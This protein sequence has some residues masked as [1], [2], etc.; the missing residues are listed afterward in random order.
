MINIGTLIATLKLNDKLTP[1]LIKAQ[2]SI[3][4]V[5]PKL[6]SLGRT[7][8]KNVTLGMAAA[9]AATL[10]ASDTIQEAFRAISSTTGATGDA[11]EG[12]T[13]SFTEVFTK[14]PQGAEVVAGALADI[15]TISGATGSVLESLTKN[16]LDASRVLGENAG[17]NAIG[18]ARALEQF[19]RPATEGTDILDRFFR[20]SQETGSGLGDLIRQTNEYGGVLKNAGFSME[21]SAVLFG[22][23][24]SSGIS[25]SRAMPGLNA[26]FRKSADAGEN[27]RAMLDRVINSMKAA[28]SDTQALSIATEVFGAEGAQRMTVAVRNGTFALD[29]LTSSLSGAEGGIQAAS[30]ESQTLSE[31]MGTLRNKAT[32]A[33]APFGDEL[34]VVLLSFLPLIESLGEHI[35]DASFWFSQLSP[36][37]KKTI[38]VITGLTAAAG[39]LLFIV[40]Q[41]A[42][43]FGAISPY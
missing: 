24:E 29:D 19:Q 33:L 43:A 8:T 40:G 28:K 27:S 1:A 14:V 35:K 18:F 22:R 6:T 2:Q 4:N 36:A 21:E 41:L 12:L 39:P 31:V 15:N 20:I 16:V 37:A 25:V 26:A 32:S 3:K 42:I 9:S 38:V 7:L 34:K 5:G 30:A 17:P 23:L 10:M 11:L 13:D